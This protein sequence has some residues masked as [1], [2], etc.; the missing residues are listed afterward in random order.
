MT[1]LNGEP[2]PGDAFEVAKDLLNLTPAN[3]VEAHLLEVLTDLTAAHERLQGRIERAL[4]LLQDDKQ[5]DAEATLEAA[6]FGSS[7]Q[8]D[9]HE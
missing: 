6:V 9:S 5:W 3:V 8:E 4:E 7:E 1:L 2:P